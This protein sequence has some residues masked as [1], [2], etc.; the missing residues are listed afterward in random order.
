[1]TKVLLLRYLL[2]CEDNNSKVLS[3]QNVNIPYGNGFAA[4]DVEETIKRLEILTTSLRNFDQ[5]IID[6]IRHCYKVQ[7][8]RRQISLP[9]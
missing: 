3:M 2:H 7:K 5:E 4:R 1:M 6:F 8:A 9:N